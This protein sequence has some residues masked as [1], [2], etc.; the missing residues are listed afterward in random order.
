MYASVGRRTHAVAYKQYESSSDQH[1]GY[2]LRPHTTNSTVQVFKQANAKV[3]TRMVESL[4]AAD[5]VRSAG[6]MP[7]K[8]RRRGADANVASLRQALAAC[9]D[10]YPE[11]P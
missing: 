1:Y 10:A 3:L 5:M 8:R 9:Q 11:P 4:K 2:G 6:R 7:T